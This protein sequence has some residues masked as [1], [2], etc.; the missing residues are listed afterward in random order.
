[1][2]QYDQVEQD[3]WKIVHFV[4]NTPNYIMPNAILVLTVCIFFA[5]SNAPVKVFIV[6]KEKKFKRLEKYDGKTTKN[7]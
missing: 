7:W 1:M 5:Q 4:S 3:L 2:S 6:L